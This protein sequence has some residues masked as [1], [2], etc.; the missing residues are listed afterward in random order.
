MRKQK[1]ISIFV[2]IIYLKT[3]KQCHYRITDWSFS[4]SHFSKT[5]KVAVNKITN[6]WL[7]ILF[8]F[9]ECQEKKVKVHL[10]FHLHSSISYCNYSA[11]S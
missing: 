9:A 6:G 10:D 2:F 1:N 4:L 7:K 5:Y 8:N 3:H 11:T